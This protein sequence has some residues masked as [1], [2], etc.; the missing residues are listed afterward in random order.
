MLVLQCRPGR[1]HEKAA[2]HQKDHERLDPPKVLAHRLA[3]SAALELNDFRCHRSLPHGIR[4]SFKVSFAR[5]ARIVW[6][7]YS[8]IVKAPERKNASGDFE[9]PE[10]FDCVDC[11]CLA[12]RSE[13]HTSELQSP[14][15]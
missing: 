4:I 9:S 1:V 15:N 10:A 5:V 8:H 6:P 13:E 12:D 2:Q 14:C 11:W 7:Y 3:E